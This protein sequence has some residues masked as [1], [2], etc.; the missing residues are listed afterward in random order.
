MTTRYEVAPCPACGSRA[1]EEIAGTAEIRVE[2]EQL[3]AFHTRRV[4]GETPPHL[5][6][7]RAAFSQEPPLRLEGCRGC[8]MLF[9]NPRERPD[10]L[11]ETY[12]GE[13]PDE[14]VL[15]TLFETQRRSYAAQVRRL[16]RLIGRPGT[17]LEVGSYV[18]AFLAA[19]TAQ[20]WSFRGLDVNPRAVAFA[21]A[22]GLHAGAGAIED[23]DED[24]AV[25]VVAFWNC[26]DQL[27]DP[28]SAAR[29]ARDRLRPGGLLAVRV[30]SGAFYRTWRKR[31]ATPSAPLARALLAHSNLLGFPYRLGFTLDSLRLLLMDAGFGIEHVIGDAL[32]PVADR[33]TR[34]WA[35]AEERVLKSLLRRLPPTR[36]PWLEV[37]A[38]AV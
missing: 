19:A 21:T 17:G 30:P 26:F 27:P 20:G 7:D 34:P 4:R 16:Q 37:Y 36:A 35:A 28:R 33:W 10:E 9:R 11:V 29:A 15:R 31:L 25:D 5:L 13:E 22:L 3:W 23:A 24:E 32:V 1:G 8:G 38:R 12:S 14:A 2:L 6:L 18:G